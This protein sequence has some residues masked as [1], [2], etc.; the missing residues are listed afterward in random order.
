MESLSKRYLGLLTVVGIGVCV[1]A[2]I[3]A[4]P[5]REDQRLKARISEKI[6]AIKSAGS[7]VT[8]EDLLRLHP[9]PPP[10]QDATLVLGRVFAMTANP[11]QGANVPL[12]GGKLPEGAANMD[13]E[14]WTT[15][16]GFLESNGPALAALPPVIEDAWFP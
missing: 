3:I 14:T 4:R 15:I 16:E 1:I 10:E 2:W 7:P 6:A 13:D 11:T 12:L 5:S 9:N 8:A